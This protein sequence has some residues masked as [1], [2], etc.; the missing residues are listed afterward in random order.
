M[1]KFK[2]DQ[3][4]MN[5]Q[6]FEYKG[7]FHFQL[8]E[9]LMYSRTFEHSEIVGH[10]TLS[11]TKPLNRLEYLFDSNSFVLL[12]RKYQDQ[13]KMCFSRLSIFSAPYFICLCWIDLA[14][15]R[16]LMIPSERHF[17]QD[18]LATN[19]IIKKVLLVQYQSSN[20]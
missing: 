6:T 9:H 1:C 19:S 12:T 5:V 3:T 11:L 14:D 17:N 7:L 15:S 4:R 18:Q 10:S 20:P 13:I 2:Q 8:D 16:L